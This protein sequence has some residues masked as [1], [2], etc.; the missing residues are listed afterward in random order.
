MCAVGLFAQDALYRMPDGVESRWASPENP[1][2]ERSSGGKEN[3]GRKGRPMVQLKAREQLVL[4][5]ANG[6]SGTV[7]RIWVTISDRSPQMLRGLR[8]DMFWDGAR[9]PAVSAPFGDFFGVGLGRTASFESALFADPEGR[10][11]NCYVPMPF[12]TGMKIAVTN[13]SGR[14]LPMLFYDVDYTVGDKHGPD[15]M[16]FHAHWRRESPTKMQKD[17]EILPRVEGRGRYLGANFGVISDQKH[18][19]KTWW[20]EG[21]VKVYL[22]GDR[23]QPTLNGTGTEDYIGT[24]WGQGKYSHLYQGCLVADAEHMQ[25]CF[26]RYHVP[27]PDL[28]P[29]RGSRHHPADRLSR[30]GGDGIDLPLEATPLQGWS[31]PRNDG[32]FDRRAL[33]TGRRLVEHRLF[34]SRPARK[35][36]SRA[37]RRGTSHGRAGA[38]RALTPSSG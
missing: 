23:E 18:Y 1:L 16:Y 29:Q 36:S 12:R 24:G 19:F 2:G 21:E 30:P 33:R 9:T 10:S 7:R 13:E 5:E 15:A 11:F 25:Y 3:A 20:G 14:D 6:T 37:G 38:R 22:D 8:I 28:L 34:L 26:Y 31:G 32:R 17:F 35:W 27:D 4:A